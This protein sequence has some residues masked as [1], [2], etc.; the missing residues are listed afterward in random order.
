MNAAIRRFLYALGFSLLAALATDARAQPSYQGLWWNSPADSENGWGLNL[1][2]QGDILFGTWFTYDAQGRGMWL[3][4]PRADLIPM[5]MGDG[6]GYGGYYMPGMST[7][8]TYSGPLFRPSGPSSD[9]ATFDNS[10]V[11]LEPVG[12]AT[13][14]FTSAT[15]GEFSYSVDNIFGSKSITLLKYSAPP[16][17]SFEVVPGPPTTN[18]QDLW[19]RSPA[20]SENGWGVNIAHQGDILFATWFTYD[21]AGHGVWY[22]MSDGEKTGA[23]TYAGKLFQTTGAPF[24]ATPWDKSLT[25]LNEVGTATFT[26]SDANNGTFTAVVHGATQ[27]KPITRL[28]FSAPSTVCR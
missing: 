25:K 27:V 19:W 13:L 8:Y 12:T 17:C 15:T 10:A 2:H 7:T 20:A 5:D 4:M 18:Y 3:V 26:F 16:T 21:S 22:V 1:T 23:R 28:L 24:S 11:K 6:Y 14:V 9:L